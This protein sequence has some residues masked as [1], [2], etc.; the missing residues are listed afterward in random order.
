MLR[1]EWNEGVSG[2]LEETTFLENKMEPNSAAVFWIF[3]QSSCYQL[4]KIFP[5]Q[6]IPAQPIESLQI[7]KRPTSQPLIDKS[8]R[9]ARKC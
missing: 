3:K 8:P 2:L 6:D 5:A 1:F 9:A 7:M 4:F